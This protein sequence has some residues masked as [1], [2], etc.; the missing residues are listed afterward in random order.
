MSQSEQDNK[1]AL[2]GGGLLSR[3]GTSVREVVDTTSGASRTRPQPARPL[4]DLRGFAAHHVGVLFLDGDFVETLP[5]G[6]YA[7][8]KNMA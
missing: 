8:W 7:F 4:C 3:A 1:D 5:P 2:Q 6:R